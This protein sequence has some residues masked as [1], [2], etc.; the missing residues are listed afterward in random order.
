MPSSATTPKAI[1]A[2]IPALIGAA[3]VTGAVA[4]IAAG[5]VLLVVGTCVVT[6][7][8]EGGATGV[9]SAWVPYEV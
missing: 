6:G 7:L 2:F 5:R 4:V 3:A 8:G 1:P 9:L